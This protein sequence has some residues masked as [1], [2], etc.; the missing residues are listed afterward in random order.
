VG[1]FGVRCFLGYVAS[2][3]RGGFRG[4]GV[5]IKVVCFAGL[6]FVLVLS[7]WF[8]FFWWGGFFYGVMFCFGLVVVCGLVECLG[9]LVFFGFAVGL[10]LGLWVWFFL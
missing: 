5:L 8:V 6:V 7:V 2:F 9:N 1:F 3:L 10:S 4:D